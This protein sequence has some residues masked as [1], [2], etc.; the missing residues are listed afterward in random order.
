M[1]D[2]SFSVSFMTGDQVTTSQMK[3]F[4]FLLFQVLRTYTILK[5]NRQMSQ[6]FFKIFEA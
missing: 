4:F 1:K 5:T 6:S 2:V 3:I